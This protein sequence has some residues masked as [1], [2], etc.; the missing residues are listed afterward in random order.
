M[1]LLRTDSVEGEF[2]QV[3]AVTDANEHGQHVRCGGDELGVL[4]RHPDPGDL[5][6]GN[7]ADH[8][9]VG[10]VDMDRVHEGLDLPRC[11]GMSLVHRRGSYRFGVAR[12]GRAG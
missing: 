1:T 9:S 2:V 6:V 12:W 3:A 4:G 10:V 8:L 5:A 11:R 7:V